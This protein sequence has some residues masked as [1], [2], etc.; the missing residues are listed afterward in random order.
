MLF[1]SRRR[2]SAEVVEILDADPS[3]RDGDR[4]HLP[5]VVDAYRVIR[6]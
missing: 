3:L 5:F 1:R 4:L 6:T 2:V